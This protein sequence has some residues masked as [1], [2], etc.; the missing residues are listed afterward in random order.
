[1]VDRFSPLAMLL[2]GNIDKAEYHVG[3]TSWS[4]GLTLV[5]TRPR[6]KKN[7]KQGSEDKIHFLCRPVR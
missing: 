3:S 2:L 4:R 6:N 5:D 1:M 7:K